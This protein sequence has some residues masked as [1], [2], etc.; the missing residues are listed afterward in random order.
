[1]SIHSGREETIGFGLVGAGMIASY[2]VKAIA[3]LA[4]IRRRCA[5]QGIRE[6]PTEELMQ[7]PAASPFRR[8]RR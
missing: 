7:A 8:K 4:A 3:A 6:G 5:K 1:M 2:Y